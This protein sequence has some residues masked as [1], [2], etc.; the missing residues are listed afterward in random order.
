MIKGAWWTISWQ[1]FLQPSCHAAQCEEHLQFLGYLDFGWRKR[2]FPAMWDKCIIGGPGR[3]CDWGSVKGL[4][5]DL[6]Q[7]RPLQEWRLEPD[8]W[9]ESKI[10][11]SWGKWG[12]YS[13]QD[14]S[15]EQIHRPRLWWLILCVNVAGMQCRYLVKHYS[16]CLLRVLLGWDLHI[17]DFE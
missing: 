9:S 16:G 12:R 3:R 4:Y 15:Y 10:W 11:S 6:H 1:V 2:L 14:E 7:E 8:F 5:P 17:V 13:Q